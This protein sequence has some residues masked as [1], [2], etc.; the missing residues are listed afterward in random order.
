WFS[1]KNKGGVTLKMAIEKMQ[2]MD[3]AGHLP[4][5]DETLEK[6]I[7][8]Q[9][10]HPEI[11]IN[12][13]EKSTEFISLNGDNTYVQ[14]LK[15]LYDLSQDI[16]AKLEFQSNISDFTTEQAATE[17]ERLQNQVS[18]L[19]TEKRALKASI[20]QYEEAI[21]LIKHLDGLDVTF[22]EIFASDYVKVRFGKL[23]YDSYAKL[24]FYDKKT[25][26]FFT[27]DHDSDYYWGVYFAPATKIAAIDEIF[28]SLY[29]ERLRVP[30]YAHNKP[31]VAIKTISE[32]LEKDQVRLTEIRKTLSEVK[33]TKQEV[34]NSC[35]TV[36]KAASDTFALRKH[37]AVVNNSF[38]LEG[39]VPECNA[40]DL[41]DQINN[42][43]GVTCIINDADANPS[44]TPPTKLKNRRF[45]KPFQM[46]VGMY[47]MPS[48]HEF[49]PTTL[50]AVTYTLLFGA[51][52]GDLGQG[53][54]VAL[55]GLFLALAKKMDFGRIMI[56]LGISSACFGLLEGS[57]FGMEN[58]LDSFWKETLG[59]SFLPI[60]VFDNGVTNMLLLGAVA[61]GA[62]VIAIAMVINICIGLKHKNYERAVFGNNGI[63]GLVL[64]L[65][66]IGGAALMLLFQ[67]NVLNPFFIIFV[68]V[69]PILLIFFREPLAK[70]M[71][72]RKD[73][74]PE[75]GIGNFI[76]ENFFE[77][78]EYILSYLSNTMSFLRVGGFVLSHAGM[79]AVVISL[80]EMMTGSGSI[81]VMI[82]GNI[83]VMCLEGMIVGIQ[84]L[85]LEFYEIFSRFY[86]GDGKEY[87]P[88]AISY[89]VD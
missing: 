16:H 29:F 5:L 52:F 88:A 50:V 76:M 62:I 44:L 38:Y 27:F 78:F 23:P 83:F 68:V 9:V 14:S 49:D 4:D 45:S 11:G 60:K 54:V 70:L 31:E 17:I 63:A 19:A 57:V 32:M 71:Q 73:I 56:R 39:F 77:L 18:E 21:V 61:I 15:K 67:V 86:S 48:Y 30:D 81:V 43:D 25:F 37:V 72:K 85:R 41:A 58:V 46:F 20:E 36:L 42:I 47:G 55:I 89:K 82:L 12:T 66:S 24:N 3:I 28:K 2:L 40:Q 51:M 69:I 79:M 59:V 22:D 34:L 35:F 64:Y 87:E 26:F 84:M 65:G 75:G 7:E 74:K 33:D 8:S 10:F 1:N 13:S 53:L 80:S 6:C